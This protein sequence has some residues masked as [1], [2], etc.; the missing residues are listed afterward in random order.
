MNEA[1]EVSGMR[2][3]SERQWH[4]AALAGLLLTSA[5]TVFGQSLHPRLIPEPVEL[6]YQNGEIDISRLCVPT[7]SLSREDMFALRTLLGG[8]NVAARSCSAGDAPIQLSSTGKLSSVPIPGEIAGPAS[9][10]AYAI[11]IARDG[12][13]VTGKSS[14]SIF[15]GVQTILQMIEHDTSGHTHL[16][17]AT[18]KDWP[19]LAYRGTLMDAGSEG[20][21]LTVDEVK[22]QI[23]FIS[24]WK[25]NQ[26]FFYSEGNIELR[27]YPLLNPN[28]RFTQDQIREIVSYARDRHIDV[29]PAVE[30]YA[31]LHDLFRI[32]KYSDLADFPHGGEFNP[33]DPR[34]KA[35]LEDWVSQLSA[36]FPSK[37]VDVGFDETWSL[38]KAAAKTGADSTPVQLFVHQLTTVT[39]YADIMVKYPGIVPRLPKGLIALPWWYEATPDPEYKHWLDPLVQQQVPHIVTTG[40]TS[41]DQIAPDFTVSFENIDTFLAAGRK[42][43]ALGLLNTL[44]TDDGQALLQMSWPGMAYGAAAAW[45]QAPMAPATFLD[46]YAQLRYSPSVATDLAQALI[47]LNRAEN[48]LQKAIGNE[49]MLELWRDPFRTE[50]LNATE[51][52]QEELH[53]SRLAAEDAL[54]HLYAIRQSAPATMHLESFIAGAQIIDLAALKFISANEIDAAWKTLPANPTREDLMNVL[55]RGISNETHS[56]C[57]DLMDGFSETEVTYRSAWLQQY[58]TYRLG[59]ALG[60]WDAEYQFWRRAQ[61]NFERLRTSFK[62]G[63][64]LPTL[65]RITSATY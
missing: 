46:D 27:G 23:D 12:V 7:V 36:L 40:V 4:I 49:T 44:W 6:Q 9:R 45:Q 65:Q 15:Y 28:A 32:E 41:W 18:I 29:V 43:H 5:T 59:T 37:F 10:E 61:T 8:L 57:M 48:L 25:G 2:V 21:M 62:T 64:P 53:Q 50:S 55:E 3:S 30:M 17:F 14:A 47:Q 26:Y 33:N 58:N 16:P 31:H 1:N 35:I 38:Q 11:H 13:A 52:H 19:A 51:S 34:V 22:R 60:R 39:A 20:P 54:E 56:R 42:T 63:D 24:R